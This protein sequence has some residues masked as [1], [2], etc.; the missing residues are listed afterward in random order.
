MK[1]YNLK[2]KNFFSV[3][4]SDA[5]EEEG[6]K[7][8]KEKSIENIK[9]INEN[10]A[11]LAKNSAGINARFITNTK[12]LKI[13]VKLEGKAYLSHM[14]A[15]GQ[16][17]IDLY[18]FNENQQKYVFRSVTKYNLKNDFYEVILYENDVNDEVKMWINLPLYMGVKEIILT[19]D[20]NAYIKP[21]PFI[22][23]RRVLVYGTSITQGA[24]ASRPGMAY[25]SLL[26]RRFNL[27][28]LNMGFS[29]AALLEEQMAHELGKIRNINLLIIDVEANA[30]G[31]LKMKERLEKFLEIYESYNQNTPIIL[32]TRIPFSFDLYNKNAIN[33]NKMYNTWLKEL[34]LKYNKMNKQYYFLDLKDTFGKNFTEYTVDG[35][36]PTDLG[37][38][39]IYEKYE[40]LLKNIF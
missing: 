37:M 9:K 26:Q 7:R 13:K 34:V 20:E 12:L 22:D 2:D 36:H 19:V 25:C 38:F 23:K 10:A 5:L 27:E 31:N 17:G 16:C 40:G 4:G 32:T 21:N 18:I 35:T 24:C 33:L 14:A 3:Y 8:L 6:Y 11:I 1:E 15:T 39:K 28:F 29:G 30:G